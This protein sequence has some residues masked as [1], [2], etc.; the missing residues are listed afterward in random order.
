MRSSPDGRQPGILVR[1]VSGSALKH[2]LLFQLQLHLKQLIGHHRRTAHRCDTRRFE[3]CGRL[4]HEKHGIPA[5]F[6]SILDPAHPCR[7]AGAGASRN[8]DFLDPAAA[9]FIHG[10]SPFFI[11]RKDYFPKRFISE[12]SISSKKIYSPKRVFLRKD[13]FSEKLVS[14]K[15]FILRKGAWK[16]ISQLYRAEQS[17]L[18]CL[19]QAFSP[20]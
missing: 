11:F 6:K 17:R 19:G 10:F 16:N 7:L 1:D 12:K 5:L 20:V 15:R 4:L 3:F 13:L 2:P 14:S 8:D 9:R 18:F